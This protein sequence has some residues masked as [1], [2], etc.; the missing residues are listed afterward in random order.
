MSPSKRNRDNSAYK[1]PDGALYVDKICELYDI[2]ESTCHARL[3]VLNIDTLKLNGWAYLT[4][5]QLAE[6][7]RLDKHLKVDRRY[8][9]YRKSQERQDA[10]KVVV[11]SDAAAEP[12]EPSKLEQAEEKVEVNDNDLVV[13]A[14][15]APPTAPPLQLPQAPLPQQIQVPTKAPKAPRRKSAPKPLPKQLYRQ[16]QRKAQPAPTTKPESPKTLWW[17]SLFRMVGIGLFVLGLSM[18]YQHKDSLQPIQTWSSPVN[19]SVSSES[20]AP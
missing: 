11:N 19:E 6:F 7:D 2:W 4:K 13:D 17:D 14:D 18:F 5:E 20:S 3:N 1:L 16:V 10:P 8:K 15:K 9:T 12:E